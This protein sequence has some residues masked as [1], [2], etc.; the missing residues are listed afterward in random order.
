MN[1]KMSEAELLRAIKDAFKQSEKGEETE[2]KDNNAVTEKQPISPRE[3]L[4]L[5][6]EQSKNKESEKDKNK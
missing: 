3:T 6:S 5:Y 1:D 4:P 2:V